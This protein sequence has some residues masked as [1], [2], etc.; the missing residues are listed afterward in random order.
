MR[1]RRRQC[2]FRKVE[3]WVLLSAPKFFLSEFLIKQ[4]ILKELR[5]VQ[6]FGFGTIDLSAMQWCQE[7]APT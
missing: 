5:F 4:L 1:Y 2:D 3:L 7:F 6:R